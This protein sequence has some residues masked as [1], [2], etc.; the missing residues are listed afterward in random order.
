MAACADCR[1]ESVNTVSIRGAG[2]EDVQ[3]CQ[4]CFVLWQI[5]DELS[6]FP[7]LTEAERHQVW[8]LFAATFRALRRLL[9][10]DIGAVP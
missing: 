3:V 4:E 2:D 8:L 5:R 7:D 6:L 1:C 9:R 10:Q